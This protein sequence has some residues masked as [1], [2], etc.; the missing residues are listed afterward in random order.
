MIS[1]S[2]LSDGRGAD[3]LTN[4]PPY[5]CVLCVALGV[6][7]TESFR[8]DRDLLGP[9]DD[10][11]HRTH[12]NTLAFPEEPIAFRTALFIDNGPRRAG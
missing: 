3:V 10:G 1:L 7:M 9:N 8:E 5:P 11:S 2:D 4:A 12:D 6:Q